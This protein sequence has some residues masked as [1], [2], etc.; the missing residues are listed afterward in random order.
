MAIPGWARAEVV[1]S[2]DNGFVV[3][4]S[5]AVQ[6]SP[7]DVYARLVHHIG[8]W[9]DSAHTF[10]Q[11]AHNLSIDARPMGCFCEKLPNQGGVRHMEVVYAAPG[12]AL[13]MTGAMGPL[14]GI[15]AAG[16]M[17]IALAP[18][19]GGTSLTV[20]YS[21]V[22]FQPSGMSTWAGPVDGMLGAQFGRLK[23][24]IEK[25]DPAPKPK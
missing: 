3:K 2:S 10:S 25:G 1:S 19:N 17:S 14:Q 18:A 23:N 15:A 24:Y 22:G 12:K 21:V 8:D 4:Q 11:D 6:A 20:T 5:L 16:N 7:D 13:T 9:W